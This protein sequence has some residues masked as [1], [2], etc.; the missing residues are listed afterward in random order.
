MAPFYFR[1]YPS[2]SANI[3]TGVVLGLDIWLWLGLELGLG[4]GLRPEVSNWGS[5]IF[6]FQ[7]VSIAL[8]R[9]SR[10]VPKVKSSRANIS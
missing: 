5:N 6:P 4:V 10:E 1:Y 3:Q 8:L 2:S 9:C 7:C